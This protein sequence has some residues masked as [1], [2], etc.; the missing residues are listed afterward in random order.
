LAAVEG[1]RQT[2]DHPAPQMN[3]S[4]VSH[5]R[6]RRCCVGL[7]TL[8]LNWEANDLFPFLSGLG[9]DARRLDDTSSGTD[10]LD[11]SRSSA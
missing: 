1:L 11:F 4:S 9:N 2:V 6:G 8:G 10:S 5:Y 3:R 7:H